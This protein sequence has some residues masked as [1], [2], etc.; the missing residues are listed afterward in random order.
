[1]NNCFIWR[2]PKNINLFE[3]PD[4]LQMFIKIKMNK[5]IVFDM[6]ETQNINSSFIGFL[7]YAKEYL[8]KK[9]KKHVFIKS[10]YV[11]KTLNMLGMAEYFSI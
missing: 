4:Y 1:M 8:Q 10:Q 2:F 7:I 6:T 11:E 3:V 9:G 5:E